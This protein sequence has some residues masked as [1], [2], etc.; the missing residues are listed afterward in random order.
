VFVAAQTYIY[1]AVADATKIAKARGKPK[2]DDP[3]TKFSDIV[4]FRSVTKIQVCDA[5]A[6]Y[7]KHEWPTGLL[8]PR[9]GIR[10][11]RYMTL[12]SLRA[13]II[14]VRTPPQYYWVRL[15][16][17]LWKGRPANQQYTT[18]ISTLELDTQAICPEIVEILRVN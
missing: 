17:L 11:N 4:P 10:E 8:S 2:V 18:P 14:L 9:V 13:Q 15:Q 7:F 5:I 12:E 16:D 6:N 3:L 1:G